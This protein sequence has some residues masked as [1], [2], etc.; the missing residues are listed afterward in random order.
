VVLIDPSRCPVVD[1]VDETAKGGAE[2]RGPRWS[3]ELGLGFGSEIED[4]YDQT[5]TEFG[6]ERDIAR[7]RPSASTSP[8]APGASPRPAA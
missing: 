5:L 8:G 4:S 6:Y 3:V 1:L 2:P 7:P